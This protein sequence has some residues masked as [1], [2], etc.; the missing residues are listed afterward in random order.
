M[1]N[2]SHEKHRY[3]GQTLWDIM[4]NN[5]YGFQVRSVYFF[6]TVSQGN[7]AYLIGLAGPQALHNSFLNLLARNQI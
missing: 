3:V 5:L 1:I 2:V 7:K 6:N 4:T